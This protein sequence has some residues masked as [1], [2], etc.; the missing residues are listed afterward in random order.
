MFAFIGL[1]QYIHFIY[2]S[3]GL[4]KSGRVQRAYK[5]PLRDYVFSPMTRWFE[6]PLVRCSLIRRPVGPIG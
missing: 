6:D 1:Y 5:L 2:A 4:L 3:I